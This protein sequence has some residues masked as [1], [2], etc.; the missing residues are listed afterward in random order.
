MVKKKE[1]KVVDK[2][3]ESIYTSNIKTKR[4]FQQKNI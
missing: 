4:W 1:K 2:T 3:A